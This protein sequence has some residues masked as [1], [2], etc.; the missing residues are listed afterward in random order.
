M[1]YA[2]TNNA[3]YEEKED[4]YSSVQAEVEKMSRHHLLLIMVG[5]N[6]KVGSENARHERSM[7]HDNGERLIDLCGLDNLVIRGTL[8]PHKEIH[9]LTW[10]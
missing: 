8:F 9:K 7:G 4:F 1:L 2:P 3:E 5:L 6:A 10:I